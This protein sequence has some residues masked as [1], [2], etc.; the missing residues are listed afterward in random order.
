[1]PGCRNFFSFRQSTRS[2]GKAL[3]PLF[4]AGRILRN[5]TT[6]PT[7][8]SLWNYASFLQKRTAILTINITNISFRF[9]G[10]FLCKLHYLVFMICCRKILLSCRSACSTGK[11]LAPFFC[12][13]S[14]CCNDSF[15]PCMR[16]FSKYFSL[17]QKGIAVFTI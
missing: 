4:R 13:G 8:I 2:T 5:L 9:A 16:F 11:R 1:M 15:I 14:F 12:T 7:V 10:S 6:V 3:Y 17:T